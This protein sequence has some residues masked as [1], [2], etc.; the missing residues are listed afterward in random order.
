MVP[1]WEP[2]DLGLGELSS[3]IAVVSQAPGTL[4][5]VVNET[6]GDYRV[7]ARQ[8]TGETWGS[9]KDL[10]SAKNKFNIILTGTFGPAAVATP[11]GG[12][13]A[14]AVG[15]DGAILNAHWSPGPQVWHDLRK[16]Q[17]AIS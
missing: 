15:I 14:F 1:G 6:Q 7:A 8:L 10:G 12:V 13:D 9:A 2:V 17:K 4:T 5:I 11:D 16:L 3:E